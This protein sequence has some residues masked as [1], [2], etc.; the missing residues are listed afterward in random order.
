[1]SYYLIDFINNSNNFNFDNL[2]IGRK[3]KLD[4]NMSKYYIYYQENEMEDPKEIYIK[5]P[6]LRMI[7]KLGNTKFNQ[8]NIPIYPNYDITNNFIKFIKDLEDN[9]KLC[10]ETKIQNIEFTSIINKKNN[11]SLIKTNVDDNLKISSDNNKINSLS[12]FKINGQIELVIKL[13]YIWNKNNYKIGISSYLYQ[14]KYYSSP[15]DLNYNFLDNLNNKEIIIL[16]NVNN[17]K[18]QNVIQDCIS[19]NHINL[20]SR[21]SQIVQ[22]EIK[23]VPLIDDLKSAIKNLKP[24]I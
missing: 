3:I 4:D 8:E 21:E 15:H 23:F 19:N 24:R 10:F 12:D 7:Y 14:I 20:V 13:S 22:K 1:M 11:L 17:N 18:P 16:D 5:L 2:I 6:K 9:I